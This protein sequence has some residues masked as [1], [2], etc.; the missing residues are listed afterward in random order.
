M[1]KRIVWIVAAILAAIV[2]FDYQVKPYFANRF[3]QYGYCIRLCGVAND[4]YKENLQCQ[5][6]VL[7]CDEVCW[8]AMW[9]E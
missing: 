2:L 4:W 7:N 1:D 8:K 6:D 3:R 9:S 5:A